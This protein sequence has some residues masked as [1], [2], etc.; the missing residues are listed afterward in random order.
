[1]NSPDTDRQ[2]LKAALQKA[3]NTLGLKRVAEESGV[4]Y[5]ALKNLRGQT[6][7]GHA[8][9]TLLAR[10]L[11][12]HGYLADAPPVTRT[13][14]TLT[15]DDPLPQSATLLRALADLLENPTLPRESRAALLA[16]QIPILSTL[17]TLAT[18]PLPPK[19]T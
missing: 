15:P 1:M 5:S 9:A 19:K 4:P 14:V 12:T 18:K 2:V 11:H 10:F 17:A 6:T 13:L 3:K 8:R 16:Q 7:M